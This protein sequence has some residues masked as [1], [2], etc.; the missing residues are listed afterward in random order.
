[1]KIQIQ[2]IVLAMLVGCG[3][4]RNLKLEGFQGGPPRKLGAVTAK[5]SLGP[6]ELSLYSGEVDP[7]RVLGQVGV[8]D[9]GI[10][11]TQIL[12]G[13][14]ASAPHEEL[15]EEVIPRG[16]PV[17]LLSTSPT[18]TTLAA[19]VD[20]AFERDLEHP[21][22][23][24]RTVEIRP[25]FRY[26]SQ[27]RFKGNSHLTKPIT[28]TGAPFCF[29]PEP[30]MIDCRLDPEGQVECEPWQGFAGSSNPGAEGFSRAVYT[31]SQS[32]P[33]AF[34]C[35]QWTSGTAFAYQRQEIQKLARLKVRFDPDVKIKLEV[36]SGQL[37]SGSFDTRWI[38]FSEEELDFKWVP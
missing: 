23:Y 24:S 4:S 30:K 36:P 32:E 7:A 21:L 2:F 13:S 28:C 6:T 35:Q 34:E 38:H 27:M 18:Q 8:L 31:F 11:H 1:M 17:F 37:D 12:V 16:S 5:S 20:R 22:L 9:E 26:C 10:D 19:F 15:R 14:S 3:Q 33:R 25:V 29:I